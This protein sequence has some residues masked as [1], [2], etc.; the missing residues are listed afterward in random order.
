MAFISLYNISFLSEVSLYFEA[1]IFFSFPCVL[2][3]SYF[4]FSVS[5]ARLDEGGMGNSHPAPGSGT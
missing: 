3:N 4:A 2:L 1:S 5:A